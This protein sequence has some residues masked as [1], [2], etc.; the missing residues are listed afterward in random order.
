MIL[1]FKKRPL[2]DDDSE[3]VEFGEEFTDRFGFIDNEEYTD[4]EEDI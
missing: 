4:D 1:N 3:D 2:P